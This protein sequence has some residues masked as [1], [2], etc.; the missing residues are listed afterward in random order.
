MRGLFLWRNELRK[1]VNESMSGGGIFSERELRQD[2]TDWNFGLEK[3]LARHG[4]IHPSD[5]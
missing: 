5:P 2:I 3:S 1:S 4:L